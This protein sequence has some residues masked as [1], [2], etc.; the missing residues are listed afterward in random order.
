MI[1]FEPEHV[2]PPQVLER[3]GLAVPERRL[4]AAVLEQAAMS[5]QRHLRS[6]DRHGERR[7]AEVAAWFASDD[8][9]WPFSFLNICHA[10]DLD[11]TWVRAGLGHQAP[12]KRHG[13]GR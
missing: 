13:D 11:E 2:R 7:L 6:H 3:R 1:G 8:V 10:L 9:A 12:A 5:Y 4:M